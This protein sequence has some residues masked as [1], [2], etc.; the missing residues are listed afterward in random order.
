VFS[1]G[2]SLAMLG[3]EKAV[4]LLLPALDRGEEADAALMAPWSEHMQ[5]AYDASNS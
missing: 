2:V 4:D 3:A 1:S 5:P